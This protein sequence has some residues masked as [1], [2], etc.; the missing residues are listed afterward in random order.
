LPFS[1]TGKKDRKISFSKRRVIARSQSFELAGSFVI[2]TLLI[3]FYSRRRIGR[4]RRNSELRREQDDD[5]C[6]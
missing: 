6:L 1:R 4:N 3:E 2:F 5:R